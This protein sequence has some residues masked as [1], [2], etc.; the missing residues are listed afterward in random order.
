MALTNTPA[1]PQKPRCEAVGVATAN[2][3][4]DGTGTIT[5]VITAGS[6][7]TRVTGLYAGATAT[8]GDTAV[9]FFLSKTGGASW[10]YLPHLDVLVP[11]HTLTNATANDGRV[12]AIDQDNA[13]SLF[14]LPANAMLGVT[15]AVTVA[16]G[17]MIALALGA[18]Y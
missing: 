10:T 15:I 5:P 11:A 12:A 7:G 18:D 17:Q 6:D 2:T 14:D 4:T 16:G 3:N 8:V 9:R 1:W 13:A